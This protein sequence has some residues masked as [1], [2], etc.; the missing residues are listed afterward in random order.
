MSEN[1]GPT[2]YKCYTNVLC[3]LYTLVVELQ[4][5]YKRNHFKIRGNRENNK[6]SPLSLLGNT[7]PRR[8]NQFPRPQEKNE[9]IC[10]KQDCGE[11]EM[12]EVY[13]QLHSTCTVL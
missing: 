8:G 6:F 10:V 1:I 5:W 12:K 2:L 9:G 4:A 3:L 11:R 7:I 13:F